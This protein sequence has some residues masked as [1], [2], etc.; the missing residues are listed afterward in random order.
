M[1]LSTIAYAYDTEVNY[2]IHACN[3]TSS[4][5]TL[6]L[7]EAQYGGEREL[8]SRIFRDSDREDRLELFCLFKTKE[9][10][11]FAARDKAFARLTK[12]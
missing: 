1:K 6:K 11:F 3:V 12:I 10:E 4:L 5:E 8:F 2:L 7:T 9:R